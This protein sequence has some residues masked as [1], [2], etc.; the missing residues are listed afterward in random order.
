MASLLT[1]DE[2][3]SPDEAVE[4]MVVL[5]NGDVVKVEDAVLSRHHDGYILKDES[6]WSEI[7]EDFLLDDDPVFTFYIDDDSDLTDI[8]L[9]RSTR[10]Y[11]VWQCDSSGD[12]YGPYATKIHTAGG[13]IICQCAYDDEYFTCDD[14]GDVYH[15]DDYEE[16][17]CNRC[18]RNNGSRCA[19]KYANFSLTINGVEM[20]SSSQG[21]TRTDFVD[22]ALPKD[23]LTEEAI[24]SIKSFVNNWFQEFRAEQDDNFKYNNWLYEDSIRLGADRERGGRPWAAGDDK[25]P[26]PMD[27]SLGKGKPSIVKRISKL[28]YD[29]G[30]IKIPPSALTEIGNIASRES[31][32]RDEYRMFFVRDFNSNADA[33][34]HS[35]SCW[36]ESYY[37][38]RCLLKHYKSIGMLMDSGDTFEP[39]GRCW[40]LGLDESLKPE[41]ADSESMDCPSYFVFN[42][43]GE[44]CIVWARILA[45]LKGMTYKRIDIDDINGN[46]YIN[47]SEKSGKS[48]GYIV[49]SQDVISSLSSSMYIR[50]NKKCS[51]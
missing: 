44:D 11:G 48:H 17:Y 39:S 5:I 41:L 13:S 40:A 20:K 1:I 42:A 23:C 43:Y 19:E 31:S 37:Q 27:W 50:W 51:C 28:F 30:G 14:C 26:A 34:T 15:N 12:W 49:S 16:G 32:S 25:E 10:S 18:T 35:S 36:W 4:T 8:V 9:S 21:R 3:T 45:Q 6:V 29:M 2:V 46:V 33:F 47:R 22:V 24:S 38:G 7:M